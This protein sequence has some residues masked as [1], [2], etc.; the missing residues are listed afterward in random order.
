MDRYHAEGSRQ[1][2]CTYC[3]EP[4]GANKRM[5]SECLIASR[6]SVD[7][8]E[9]AEPAEVPSGAPDIDP[10][11]KPP[12]GHG[13]YLRATSEPRSDCPVCVRLGTPFH[14]VWH[15]VYSPREV[16][17]MAK[18]QAGLDWLRDMSAHHGSPRP[19]NP[20]GTA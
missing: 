10:A 7:L 9:P 5:H 1:V 16:D 19:P 17:R 12:D 15:S 4:A 2:N 11:G 6:T 13:R 3:G 18:V 14:G 20:R 8:A